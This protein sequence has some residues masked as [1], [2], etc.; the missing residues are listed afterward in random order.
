[1]DLH[2]YIVI[3]CLMFNLSFLWVFF[4]FL[5][6]Q[7]FITFIAANDPLFFF[8]WCNLWD[9]INILYL[10]RQTKMLSINSNQKVWDTTKFIKYFTTFPNNHIMKLQGINLEKLKFWKFWNKYPHSI[11]ES[12]NLNFQIICFEVK[13]AH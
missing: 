12:L 9:S 2:S 4:F 3:W 6:I 10:I 13:I 8:G 5:V 1:M 11:N 7:H